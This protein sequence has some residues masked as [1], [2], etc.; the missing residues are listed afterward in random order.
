MVALQQGGEGQFRARFDRRA[1]RHADSGP[2]AKAFR[3]SGQGQARP[4]CA[5]GAFGLWFDLA[6]GC[7]GI[8]ARVEL[9]RHSELE[10]VR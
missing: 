6:Q 8:D 9:G 3:R 1:E 2:Q 4:A 7:L 10:V 5:C